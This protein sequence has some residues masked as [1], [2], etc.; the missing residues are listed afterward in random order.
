MIKNDKKNEKQKMCSSIN[1]YNL[2]F[3]KKVDY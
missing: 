2:S 1:L 3:V